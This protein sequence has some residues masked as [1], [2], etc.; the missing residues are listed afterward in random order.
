MY[1]ISFLGKS[2]GSLFDIKSDL[3]F[4]GYALKNTIKKYNIL[5]NISAFHLWPRLFFLISFISFFCFLWVHKDWALFSEESFYHYY[6]GRYLKDGHA[7]YW[8][9]PFCGQSTAALPSSW[10]MLPIR[11]FDAFIYGDSTQTALIRHIGIFSIV[12]WVLIVSLAL[13]K[14]WMKRTSIFFVIAVVIT[15]TGLGTIRY[16]M[17]LNR[18][19][20]A[21]MISATSLSLFPFIFDSEHL[22]KYAESLLGFFILFLTE[23]MFGAHQKA[24]FFTPIAYLAILYTIK[25]TK[26]K[27]ACIIILSIIIFSFYKWWVLRYS[28]PSDEKAF[29]EYTLIQGINPRLLL[30]DHK[31]FIDLAW[32]SFNDIPSLINNIGLAET[33]WVLWTPALKG[34]GTLIGILNYFSKLFFVFCFFITVFRI[35]YIFF[36]EYFINLITLKYRLRDILK[37]RK[38][39]ISATIFSCLFIFSVVNIAKHFYEDAIFMPLIFLSAML[40]FPLP[41]SRLEK[42][43][44]VLIILFLFIVSLV[45]QALIIE[46]GMEA[47]ETYWKKFMAYDCCNIG[48]KSAENDIGGIRELAKSCGINNNKEYSHIGVDEYTALAMQDTF[49]PVNIRWLR[50]VMKEM[51]PGMA[52]NYYQI[53]KLIGSHGAVFRCSELSNELG[54][55]RKSKVE[56]D[57]DSVF[58]CLSSFSE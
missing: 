38:L 31:R 41:Q 53:M 46:G 1:F 25:D 7:N 6:Y 55:L 56:H 18:P 20:L 4:R 10:I 43:C 23:Y 44:L 3:L 8:L 29:F 15:I 33:P 2:V 11:Y 13:H 24:L 50:E 52:Q 35:I 51:Y 19:E 49:Q 48:L 42:N 57:K 22:N 26:I 17:V 34:G 5:F 14:V 54:S 21:I 32:K 45:C 30:T 12:Y 36:N 9:W 47:R 58:C 27:L 40:I 16:L 37:N 28:C 39:L